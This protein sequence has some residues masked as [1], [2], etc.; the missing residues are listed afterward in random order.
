MKKQQ[1]T[2]LSFTMKDKRLLRETLEKSYAMELFN[3]QHFK[4]NFGGKKT[5]FAVKDR[6][7][8]LNLKAHE[9]LL[10]N[11]NSNLFQNVKRPSIRQ[12]LTIDTRHEW[13]VQGERSFMGN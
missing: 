2:I 3:W 6:V 1:K 13:P 7:Y 9:L 12:T 11:L 5:N 10:H 4:R 8:R